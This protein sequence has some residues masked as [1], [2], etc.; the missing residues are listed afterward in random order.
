[1]LKYISA[2]FVHGENEWMSDLE[3]MCSDMGQTA[4]AHWLG[5]GAA[6]MKYFLGGLAINISLQ[7]LSMEES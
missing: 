4:S 5:T 3:S 2:Y 1:M 6:A 7:L